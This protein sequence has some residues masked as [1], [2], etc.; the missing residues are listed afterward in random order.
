M[1]QKS[2]L[3]LEHEGGADATAANTRLCIRRIW[4]EIVCVGVVGWF[5]KSVN[6]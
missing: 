6:D 4:F 1:F 5:R 3:L 2:K